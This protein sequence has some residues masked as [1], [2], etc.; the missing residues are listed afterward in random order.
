MPEQL[1]NGELHPLQESEMIPAG[2]FSFFEKNFSEYPK[3]H[4][5]S[6]LNQ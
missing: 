1:N 2:D 3:K 5:L 6:W 4:G